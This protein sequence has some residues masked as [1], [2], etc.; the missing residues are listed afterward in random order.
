M[1]GSNDP[2]VAKFAASLVLR[3]LAPV[4]VFSGANGRLTEHWPQTEAETFAAVALAEGLSPEQIVVE[5]RATNTGENIAFTRAALRERGVLD[6]QGRLP[7]G[8]SLI[9]V[10]KPYMIMRSY[11]SWLKQWPELQSGSEEGGGGAPR[12]VV[13]SP[14]ELEY[15]NYPADGVIA[16]DELVSVMVGDLQRVFLY[17]RTGFQ[18]DVPIP[19]GVW[20]AF[21]QLVGLGFVGHLAR[22]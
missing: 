16:R 22:R 18:I 15:A 9:V 6:A 7:A 1:P 19:D 20:H 11:A 4:V 2:R 13:A 3:G 12:I 14:P 21:A 8:G 17:P 5:N 10:Q